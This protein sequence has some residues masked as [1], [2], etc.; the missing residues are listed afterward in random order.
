ME[1]L[2]ANEGEG[3]GGRHEYANL[4]EQR[5]TVVSPAELQKNRSC[6]FFPR[7]K[8]AYSIWA[9]KNLPPPSMLLTGVRTSVYYLFLICSLKEG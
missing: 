9:R 3:G 4:K 1:L 5:A 7:C 2:A 8:N 6:I